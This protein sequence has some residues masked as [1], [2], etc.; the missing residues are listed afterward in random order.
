VAAALGV[1]QA[2][3]PRPERVVAP[4]G[5]PRDAV[6]FEGVRFSYPGAATDELTDVLCGVDLELAAGTSTALVGV[7][8]AG[9][10]TL[11][12]SPGCAI[13]RSAGSP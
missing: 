6:R 5:V 11:V 2:A 1:E 13:R 9:K 12:C 4:A 8:G 7:N 3:Q 10:S